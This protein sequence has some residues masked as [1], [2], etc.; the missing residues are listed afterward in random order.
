[1]N[2]CIRAILSL[3]NIFIQLPSADERREISN[4]FASKYR[5]IT[6]IGC[7]DGTLII[8]SSE[9]PSYYGADMFTRKCYYALNVLLICDNVSRI[10][11]CNAGW[12][13]SVYDNRVFRNTKIYQSTQSYFSEAEYLL[14]DPRGSRLETTFEAFNPR[15]SSE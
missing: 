11:Y 3:H 13:G 12:V 10:R 14:V 4:S 15:K 9:R 7:I 5:F 1:M 8:P 2:R 6:C